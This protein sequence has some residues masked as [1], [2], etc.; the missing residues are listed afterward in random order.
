MLE[1]EGFDAWAAEYDR[2]V[3]ETDEASGYPFAGYDALMSWLRQEIT[4]GTGSCGSYMDVGVGTGK[5]AGELYD[6]GIPVCGIDF[7]EKML[8]EAARR[9]PEARLIC[10]DFSQGLPQELEDERF[11]VI[12]CTYAIHHLDEKQKI[13]LIKQMLSRL[14]TGGRLYIGDVA[15]ATRQELEACREAAGRDWDEEESYPVA[16]EIAAQL[17][18]NG[19]PQMH[20][21]RFSF[22]AGVMWWKKEN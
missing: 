14:E 9:M 6:V 20:F 11:D 17:P 19:F 1:K 4:A 15:F 3:R 7:S 12:V 2:N 22:C 8:E 10:H 13:S 16:E 5:L 21:R 18:E